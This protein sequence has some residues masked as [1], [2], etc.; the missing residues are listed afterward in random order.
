MLLYGAE[1]TVLNSKGVGAG[2]DWIVGF[3]IKGEVSLS[4]IYI[5]SPTSMGKALPRGPAR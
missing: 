3:L 2:C 5:L 4:L 1:L